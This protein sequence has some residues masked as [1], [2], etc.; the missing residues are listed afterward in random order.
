MKAFVPK[1][2][3]KSEKEIELNLEMLVR[4]TTL[5]FMFYT[6]SASPLCIIEKK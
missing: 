1:L 4:A 2:L 5:H 6:C 3:N